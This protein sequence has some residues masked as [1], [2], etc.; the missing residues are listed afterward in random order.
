M[1]RRE[2]NIRYIDDVLYRVRVK[3]ISVMGCRK[4]VCNECPINFLPFYFYMTRLPFECSR[5]TQSELSLAPL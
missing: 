1:R 5:I 2:G 4:F 3:N